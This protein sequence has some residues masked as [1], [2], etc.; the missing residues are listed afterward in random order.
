M[1]RREQIVLLQAEY[2]LLMAKRKFA[3]APRVFGRLKSLMMRELNEEA[4]FAAIADGDLDAATE[5]Y[6]P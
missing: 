2:A 1:T 6:R 5:V 4:T 3:E